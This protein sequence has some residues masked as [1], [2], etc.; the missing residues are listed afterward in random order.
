MDEHDTAR[1]RNAADPEQ[2]RRGGRKDRDDERRFTDALR[3]VMATPPGR[4]LVWELFKRAGLDE[5]VWDHSGSQMYFNEGR[6]NFGLALKAAVIEASEEL[7]LEMEREQR[8]Y[9]RM[10]ARGNAASRTARASGGE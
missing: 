5:T 9:Q 7:Y 3:A 8:A 6:R 4:I 2:V 1:V 10:D